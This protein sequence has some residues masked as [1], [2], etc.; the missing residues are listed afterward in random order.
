MTS[1]KPNLFGHVLYNYLKGDK[2]PYG[3]RRDDGWFESLNN[4]NGYFK[5]GM[6][7]IERKGLK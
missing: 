1:P 6:N 2:T 4:P 3:I 7:E 5:I